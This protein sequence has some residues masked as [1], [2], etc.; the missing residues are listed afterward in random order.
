MSTTQC[1]RY[2][3]QM[4]SGAQCEMMSGLII[5]IE[6]WEQ[7]KFYSQLRCIVLISD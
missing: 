2:K 5:A 1:V 3:I 7:I 4:L 6:L